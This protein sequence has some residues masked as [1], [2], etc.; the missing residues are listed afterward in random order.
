MAIHILPLKPLFNTMF[1]GSSLFAYVILIIRQNVQYY[2]I[3][4]HRSDDSNRI[5]PFII[6]VYIPLIVINPTHPE[7]C[8]L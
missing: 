2:E 5:G 4:P 1:G 7:Y 8:Q 6:I 3:G